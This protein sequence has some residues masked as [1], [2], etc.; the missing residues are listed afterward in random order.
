VTFCAPG[1]S[2]IAV[3]A[4][5]ARTAQQPQARTAMRKVCGSAAA[6]LVLT[7]ARSAMIVACSAGRL[8]DGPVITVIAFLQGCAA[9]PGIAG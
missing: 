4:R 3:L 9:I 7:L 5:R 6:E 2:R 8:A 1:L